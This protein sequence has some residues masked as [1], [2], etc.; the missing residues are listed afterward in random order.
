M[1]MFRRVTAF[2]L[3]L[4]MLFPDQGMMTLAGME[5]EPAGRISETM[6][7]ESLEESDRLSETFTLEPVEGT[8]KITE[9]LPLEIIEPA[10]DSEQKDASS[11][12]PEG[13]IYWNPGGS[14]PADL[15]ATASDAEERDFED[16]TSATASNA[17][18]ED[19]TYLS[20][21]TNLATVSNAAE[22]NDRADGLSPEHP[23]K[24]L[25][26]AMLRAD[27]LAEEYGIDK[28]EITIYAMSPMEVEDG[29]MYVLNGGGIRIAS[30]DGRMYQNDTVFYLNG[31]QLTLMNTSL[32]SGRD[33]ADEDEIQLVRVDGGALQLGLGVQLDGRIVMDYRRSKEERDWDSATDSNAAEIATA[34]SWTEAGES[35]A[36]FSIHD[37]I[38][39]T[40]EDEWELLEDT[41]SESTW[42]EPIIELIEGFEGIDG[43][44]LL[45]IRGDEDLNTVTLARTLYADQ[46]SN[47]EFEGFFRTGDLESGQWSLYSTSEGA[48]TVHDTGAADLERFYTETG[49]A[50]KSPGLSGFSPEAGDGSAS[51][52]TSAAAPLTV[53]RL[54]ASRAVTMEP[55]Y[56]NPGGEFTY[57]YID[58]ENNNQPTT[59][60]VPAGDDGPHDGTTPVAPVKSLEN[61][62]EKAIPKGGLIIVMQTLDLGG[63]R[64]EQY[65]TKSGSEQ[66]EDGSLIK[67]DEAWL[68]GDET[69]T[70]IPTLKVWSST[71]QPCLRVPEGQRLILRNVNFEGEAEANESQAMVI[72]AGGSLTVRK[73]VTAQTGYIQVNAT[74]LLKDYPILADDTEGVAVKLFY[75]GINH[76]LG[77][78]YMDVIAPTNNLMP[79]DATEQKKQETGE[80]LMACF[81]LAKLNSAQEGINPINW[82]LRQDQMGD[83][84]QNNPHKLE[85]Y[86]DY[87]YDAVYLNGVSGDDNNL[88]ATCEY[89]VKTWARAKEIWAKEMEASI[90][91]RKEA[92]Q[93]NPNLT[94][95]EM[96]QRYPHPGKI[97]ICGTVTVADTQTWELNP[98]LDYDETTNLVTEVS[99]HVIVQAADST[100]PKNHEE[101][102]TM[103]EVVGGGNLT[104]K[105]VTIR[106]H[107]DKEGNTSIH[108]ASGGTLTLT[109]TTVM[110]GERK[111]AHYTVGK[112][113]IDIEAKAVTRGAQIKAESGG[114][115]VLDTNWI[116]SIEHSQ[117]GIVADGAGTMVTMNGG[118]IQ[119][120]DAYDKEASAQKKGGGVALS[121]GAS[122]VMNGGTISANKAWEYGSG[123]YLTGQSTSFTL[124][125]G[126]VSDNTVSG[127]GTQADSSLTAYG[128]GIFGDTGTVITI[129]KNDATSDLAGAV[130]SG[131]KGYAGYGMGICS[132]G[133]LNVYRALIQDNRGD[134]TYG[135]S[136]DI[137]N[138]V[139]GIGICVLE[140]GTLNMDG[141]KIL[142]NWV[143]MPSD[144]V[145]Q[146]GG[147]IA[148][149]AGVYLGPLGT[150]KSQAKGTVANST[151]SDNRGGGGARFDSS[152][153]GGIYLGS[154]GRLTIT[155]TEISANRA[156]YGAG[157][158]AVYAQGHS[159]GSDEEALKIE[160]GNIKEN[161]ATSSRSVE[162]DPAPIKD[163]NA[164]VFMSRINA[165]IID[166]SIIDNKGTGVHFDGYSLTIR[167][168]LQRMRIGNSTGLGIRQSSGVVRGSYL[169]ISENK[170]G[171]VYNKEGTLLFKDVDVINNPGQNNPS[172]NND[173]NTGSVNGG[174]VSLETATAYFTDV[175]VE[176]NS[177]RQ[178]G[179]GIFIAGANSSIYW[180]ET[181]D[182]GSSLKGNKAGGMGGGIYQSSGKVILNF[183]KEIQNQSEGQGSNLYLGTGNTYLTKGSL[184]QPTE[185]RDGIYNVYS[186]G[187]NIYMD[188]QSV[189]INKKDGAAP[190]AI[191]LNRAIAFLIYLQTPPNNVAATLPIDL[192]ES[193]FSV[194][195]IVIKPANTE[196]VVVSYKVEL[197][198]GMLTKTEDKI[199]YSALTD[200]GENLDYSSGGK[201]PRR[202]RLGTVKVNNTLT[203]VILAGEGVYLSGAGDDT[204]TGKSPDTAV[205]TF[206]RAKAL[207][208]AE[209]DATAASEAG[210]PEEEKQG[211]APY[212]YICGS[213]LPVTGETWQLDYED[214][215]YTETN[216]AF[217]AA[218][219]AYYGKG[220]DEDDLKAQIR[221]FASF[222]NSPMI[223]VTADSTFQVDRCII[224][225]MV[226]AVSGQAQNSPVIDVAQ[227]AT[228]TLTG[229]AQVRNNYGNGIR[230]QKSAALYL[231]GGENDV[232]AQLKDIDGE[233]VQLQGAEAKL[234]MEGSAGILSERRK[235]GNEN[236]TG[237]YV[238]GS[239]AN[240]VMKDNSRI[241]AMTGFGFMYGVRNLYQKSNLTM[242]GSAKIINCTQG[243]LL[244]A[245]NTNLTMQ[246]SA[247]II[248]CT[249][250][251]L[252]AAANTKLSMQGSAEIG[253][254]GEGVRMGG[255]NVTVEMNCNEDA[256]SED[257][258]KIWTSKTVKS[259]VGIYITA[260]TGNVHMKKK[261]TICG[262]E[263]Q[264][265]TGMGIYYY[266]N[267]VWADE[268][269]HL[270]MEDNS[271][272]HSFSDGILVSR[273]RSPLSISMSGNAGIVKN[274]IGISENTN[275]DNFRKNFTL[276]M[277]GNSHISENSSYGWLT[278]PRRG[279][280]MT[281]R[282]S[283]SMTGEAVIGQNGHS[284]ICVVSSAPSIDITMDNDSAIRGN[285]Y[286]GIESV[287]QY[288]SASSNTGTITMK[289]S[290][291]IEGNGKNY[292]KSGSY[293]TGIN[294]E[295]GGSSGTS[296]WIITMEGKASVRNNSRNPQD[297]GT[298]YASEIYLNGESTLS[299]KRD[300]L[301]GD[302]SVVS[303]MQGA[304]NTAAITASGK[305]FMDG[306][307]T[308]DGRIRLM[309]G[310]NPI[311]LT[312][313]I[314]AETKYHLWLAEAFVGKN[315]VIPGGSVADTKNYKDNFE[316][317]K[318]DG[319]AK[320]K[321]IVYSSPNL[322]L[323][324]ENNVY[325]SGDGNDK[326]DG[327][328]P[329]TPVRTFHRAKELLETGY[330]TSG[331]NVIITKSVGIGDW[332][333]E[334]GVEHM[335]TDW[336]FGEGGAVTNGQ[337]GETW[338][339]V[340]QFYSKILYGS[341]MIYVDT[342]K[343]A[344]FRNITFDGG[345]VN[346][347]PA[348]LLIE[349][350]GSAVLGNGAI[351][352]NNKSKAN[353]EYMRAAGVQV[354]GGTLE[355]DG[356]IIRG[357]EMSC[358][359]NYSVAS[360]LYCSA[361]RVLFKSGQIGG[362]KS[363]VSG[364]NGTAAVFLDEGGVLEMSG[365][366]ISG[367]TSS[368][369]GPASLGHYGGGL[370]VS[371]GASVKMSGGSIQNNAG[372]RGSGVYYFANS[373]SSGNLTLSGGRISGNSSNLP[374]AGV[375]GVDSP[376]YVAAKNFTLE[377]SGCDIQDAIYLADTQYPLIVSGYMR[378]YGRLYRLFLNQGTGVNQYHKGSVVVAPDGSQSG[379]VSAA[380]PYFEVVSDQYV[381]DRGRSAQGSG[382]N[383]A[384]PENKCLILA[385]K[386]FINGETGDD[387][388][389]GLTPTS[390]VKTFT[391]AKAV[392]EVSD[393]GSQDHYIIYV[394]GKVT[395][396]ADETDWSLP[397]TAYMCRYT[398]FKVYE[399]DGNTVTEGIYPYH[400]VLIEP[401]N[402][403]TMGSIAVYGR[404]FSD[405][406]VINGDSLLSIRQGVTV[407]LTEGAVLQR[408]N[409]TGHYIDPSSGQNIAVTGEG[410]AVR[411]AAGGTLAMSAGSIGETTAAKG[412]AIFVGADRTDD[413]ANGHLILDNSP[414]V[415]GKVYLSGNGTTTAA[416]VEPQTTYAP[417]SALQLV[418]ENDYNQRRC[419]QYPADFQ[420]GATEMSYFAFEDSIMGL[421]EIVYRESAA[422]VIELNQ[423]SVIY[424]DGVNGDDSN[425]G[426]TPET[427]FKSLKK[428]YQHLH[429][430]QEEPSAEGG[431][432]V[433]VVDTVSLPSAG[434]APR[435]ALHNLERRNVQTDMPYYE[436]Y[437]QEFDTVG[438]AGEE[439]TVKGQVYFKRYAQP[440][441]YDSSDSIYTGYN[442]P[443]LLKELFYVG[444][445]STLEL[446][447]MYLDGHSHESVSV[448]PRYHAQ[449]VEAEAPLVTVT[450]ELVCGYVNST[451]DI[452]S[453]PTLLSNNVN[454][455][456]KST[457][458]D[459]GLSVG[460][461]NGMEVRQGSAAGIEILG[462]D[463]QGAGGI[464]RLN[465]TEFRNLEL[466]ENVA[467][468]AT[469]IYH[470][471]KE[472]HVQNQ[473]TF[474]GGVFLEGLGTLENTASHSSSKFIIVDAYGTPVTRTFEVLLRDPYTGRK[475][476]EYPSS[477][478]S[479]P[480]DTQIGRYRPDVFTKEFYYLAK[481]TDQKYVLELRKPQAVYI[482]GVNGDDA[483]SGI[484]PSAP[485]KSMKRAYELLNV[486]MANII[487][488]V[489]TVAIDHDM[490]LS[491]SMY[492][493]A[494]GSNDTVS[495][496]NTSTVKLARYIRPDLAQTQGYNVADFKG[497]LLE[498]LD[499]GRLS[500]GEGLIVD[501]HSQQW[502]DV[503]LPDELH[504]SRSGA[505][506]A[507]LILVQ[508]N[509]VV[510]LLE[511]LTLQYNNNTFDSGAAQTGGAGLEGG[512]IHNRGTVT[513]NGTQF[514]ENRAQ[515]GGA[516]YQAGTFTIES[517]VSGLKG[518]S[519]Y[520][521]HTAN[522]EDHVLQI[523]E[524][525]P[526]NPMQTFDLDMDHAVAGRDVIRF[527]DT[528]AYPNG[529]DAEHVHFVPGSTVPDELFLVE[530]EEDNSVLELQN[531]KILK[532][533]VPKDIYLVVN[534]MGKVQATEKLSGI[535]AGQQEL[536]GSP[537]YEIKN[538]GLYDV[539]VSITGMD[540]ANA[541]AGITEYGDIALKESAASAVGENDLYLGVKGM[542]TD[543]HSGLTFGEHALLTQ[544]MTPFELG[545]L[546]A[547]GTGTFMFTGK[548][549]TGFVDK[550][551][552]VNFPI[553]ET[554]TEAKQHM[555][556]TGENGTVNARA[557]YLLKYKVEIDPGR[558]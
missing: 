28:S 404:R 550:Y 147:E 342:G 200:A 277:A 112:D 84:N 294:L 287:N 322:M 440:T 432:V 1:Q 482:D 336:S 399:A 17:L 326:N 283:L 122:F 232:N 465:H 119:K 364:E 521:A 424:L 469:D 35:G 227:G 321:D 105:D 541:S 383:A 443:T 371:S 224:D 445:G 234:T 108:V 334:Q 142:R 226:D 49:R 337:S 46:M 538:T 530:A 430:L 400:G 557:K 164:G 551:K 475:V 62:I 522:G 415:N 150:G 203:N 484:T 98:V 540:N 302:P 73:N 44:Y 546:T 408:N 402:P 295:N 237:V 289:G 318:G 376:V 467:A 348:I 504:V 511:G 428:V 552:D 160:R 45:E 151:I 225:G 185:Q 104:V 135:G 204:N 310:E 353:T 461:L 43:G 329:S 252:L 426:Q 258:A 261:A 190:D 195:S 439:I 65:L 343:H 510:N 508:E 397:D 476:V 506:E 231:K 270:T 389:N 71:N 182:G 520:L 218:E 60:V 69:P 129:G 176:N 375:Y 41:S 31:G 472:L 139:Y 296:S 286:A 16:E 68:V 74:P 446:W 449:R 431:G 26:T 549:G 259:P 199:T 24:S 411:I 316:K 93:N 37:Y 55:I 535:L 220:V 527:T 244:A 22:G 42:R 490:T 361:G 363:E 473:T 251:V 338:A 114:S 423:R 111:E 314:P 53:K 304:E 194:G 547:G 207:L 125:Q 136:S 170:N 416:Y 219:R 33:Q 163:N 106:N 447:G 14:L 362:N 156:N 542:D 138:I 339:P 59:A 410:G 369:Y 356:G 177:A 519:F 479:G 265:K 357:M 427:A 474:G 266:N 512:A 269:N 390:A 8:G 19:D 454:V 4:L 315:V 196:N 263:P 76:N 526:V 381:V 48:A 208:E 492:I 401:E 272:I 154:G 456:D 249:Q 264:T 497:E 403:L 205:K 282:H 407:Q 499:G 159:N 211:F 126:S 378:H 173:E 86:T 419:V 10:E 514:I 532:V 18:K 495:L 276:T 539:K 494:G 174:G 30:W 117:Q 298:S 97:Y 262:E 558:R 267:N 345:S 165:T 39:T 118:L 254:C 229:D 127:G 537:E 235:A 487:F 351:V 486:N 89:P 257:S 78:R 425:D 374:N 319:L 442:K 509:G 528:S 66:K 387:N 214:T 346:D 434:T 255:N 167:G 88:G 372:G 359:E 460:T 485:I 38:F 57:T 40:E 81:S 29:H 398:G 470:F 21:Q 435:I 212:I 281:G 352:Q 171:G 121:G 178:N 96:N 109:G 471:G 385:K 193:A 233:A 245:A 433:Y 491:G 388:Q 513:V 327:S 466:G 480:A 344:V 518:H 382:W 95:E 25:E 554:E 236:R 429:S 198:N 453:T 332:T 197:K 133:T 54:A 143:Q 420:P 285:G 464:C 489:D 241:E 299:L 355:I 157:I 243:V 307:V 92:I 448:N 417:P 268:G 181:T 144:F 280:T 61:A 436:G 556:G 308:V 377:G 462:G 70:V 137:A 297:V 161:T 15:T 331:A 20:D 392:G 317:V 7:L 493:G 441:G 141:A 516:A 94:L 545:R 271:S 222:V 131:N 481:K 422:N 458:A 100:A 393:G 413:N 51:L 101:P 9:I 311:G 306:T 515:K 548:V 11:L 175:K 246:G 274:F 239:G 412:D 414:S 358:L 468:G 278:S 3:C 544:W 421:Y 99:P 228:A 169:E 517:G 360:A 50:K 478:A 455:R 350:G 483:A 184:L 324:G 63:E 328:S 162:E 215:R 58:P 36:G 525:V 292:N 64:P 107:S 459:N 188:P 396:T 238:E 180:S 247:K 347:A 320:S 206:A 67:E 221:R 291:C 5:T 149:G 77:Y 56:W 330:F 87:N 260:A 110:T 223:Q 523:G 209:V 275:Q 210:K 132:Y 186:N 153:G 191:F 444:A 534:R 113:T 365:G 312:S 437:Y 75:S 166:C 367:N 303:A 395:N 333:D 368:F 553:T 288:N 300:P 313:G 477:N 340:V 230:V 498:V 32:E 248:N 168:E 152:Q 130:V 213:V 72:E 85:L 341:S 409:N 394:C 290:S 380:L 23:V 103:V 529:A 242:Q 386:V 452:I 82:V 91:V 183:N 2:G 503:H 463:T 279:S 370:M 187:V 293:G 349:D 172:Q 47:E 155:D 115:V 301:T 273:I 500:L 140:N 335:D 501:G 123:V 488:V 201:L 406:A 384:V 284:G 507:P 128:V 253:G 145:S 124:N 505:S 391:S 52:F 240:V 373:S 405:S 309:N 146:D 83:D 323:Q 451:D 90:Q 555:D 189:K 13:A 217:E 102:Q 354:T 192:N 536:I 134:G 450:G 158:Y 148:C 438:N 418:L 533:E 366:V 305:L 543:A 116:G 502:T 531:W 79:A 34:S 27:E 457:E 256:Q 325:L 524:A 250:G 120:N 379:D 6:R 12:Q 216:K 496:L 80:K 202:T 179:G